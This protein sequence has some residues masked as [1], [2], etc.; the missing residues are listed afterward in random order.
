LARV[1]GDSTSATRFASDLPA[2]DRLAIGRDEKDVRL[3]DEIA[4]AIENDVHGRNRDRSELPRLDVG[5]PY[6]RDF[7]HHHLMRESS[8]VMVK[9][10]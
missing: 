9:L 5:G 7:E 1:P 2:H 4:V 6:T 10:R 8:G 3:R